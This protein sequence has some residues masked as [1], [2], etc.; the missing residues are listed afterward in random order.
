MHISLISLLIESSELS[1]SG[2]D[3]DIYFSDSAWNIANGMTDGKSRSII[4]YMSP[5][6]FLTVAQRMPSNALNKFHER[7]NEIRSLMSSGV[8]MSSLPQLSFEHDGQG[9]SKA[10]NHDG[11]HRALSLK[12]MGVRSMPVVLTSN[13]SKKGMA[14]RWNEQGDPNS[15]DYYKGVWPNVL[16]GETSGEIPFPVKDTR[17]K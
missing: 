14:I 1:S 15:F 2:N 13:G 6:E 10:T 3:G 5:D 16:K 17:V 8:K 11:R 4:A 9:T 7:A 12:I